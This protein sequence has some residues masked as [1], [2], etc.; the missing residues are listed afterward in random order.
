LQPNRKESEETVE[1]PSAEWT[2]L[3]YSEIFPKQMHDLRDIFVSLR[4][5][6]QVAE[7]Y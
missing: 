5:K 6:F 4:G 1:N 7:N 2:H 3:A